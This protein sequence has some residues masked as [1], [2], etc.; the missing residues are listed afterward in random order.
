MELEYSSYSSKFYGASLNETLRGVLLRHNKKI[1]CLQ[2]WPQLGDPTLEDLLSKLGHSKSTWHPL[3]KHSM[4]VLDDATFSAQA[5]RS[6]EEDA[7]NLPSHALVSYESSR[8]QIAALAEQGFTQFKIKFRPHFEPNQGAFRHFQDLKKDFTI[9][10]RLDANS[11]FKTEESFLEHWNKFSAFHNQIEFIEDPI[12]FDF[13][14]WHSLQKKGV[15]IAADR[16][17]HFISPSQVNAEFPA[18]VLVMKPI[19]HFL[20]EW[21]QTFQ[22]SGK[23]LVFTTALD[24][25]W[26][27]LWAFHSIHVMRQK[28]LALES[29]G[30]FTETLESF[31]Y[32][33]LKPKN[34]GVQICG[35]STLLAQS[36]ELE[37]SKFSQQ[38]T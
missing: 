32:N 35:L 19:R 1:T 27:Q 38:N 36:E 9:K 14:S 17:L 20:G 28:G 10:L 37:W 12:S 11:F 15:K 5:L 22:S 30:L 29:S 16:P 21:E 24:H 33:P 3:L 18:S 25:P 13:E 7:V 34:G 26:G 6:Y 4:A 2:P 8:E 23:R 31:A